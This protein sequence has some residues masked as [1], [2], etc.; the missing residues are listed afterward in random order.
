MVEEF[1]FEAETVIRKKENSA[2]LHYLHFPHCIQ[3][4][5]S[6]K[7]LLSQTTNFRLFQSERRY[8]QFLL[9]PQRFQNTFCW[10]YVKT[11]SCLGKG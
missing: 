10:R 4:L 8:E 3:E 1:A 9:L 2:Y 6:R 7:S 5:Y 11:R